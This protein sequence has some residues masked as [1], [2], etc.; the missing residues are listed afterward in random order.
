MVRAAGTA[1]APSGVELPEPTWGYLARR[2]MPAF[3]A[4][5]IVPLL[6]FYGAWKLWGLTTGIVVATA[7]SAGVVAW[8]SRRGRETPVARI[9]LVFIAV[10]AVVGL[11]A[12][13]ATVYLAQPVVLSAGW[14]IAYLTSAAIGRPLIGL[15]AQAWYPFP[16]SFRAA[17]IYR[18]EFG[19]QSVVW[20]VFLL[21]RAGLRLAAL[22]GSGAGGFILVSFATG[23][24]LFFALVAWGVWH[25]RRTF[26][27]AD[28]F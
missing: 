11:A 27:R 10:Q 21:A 6:A 5:G 24:P 7:I 16:P 12:H 14:G 18:R 28:D 2:G 17:P 3:A 8:Q 15:F 26:S 23:T 1:P 4:E 13:S 22:L 19:M 20:G 25:A 9:T